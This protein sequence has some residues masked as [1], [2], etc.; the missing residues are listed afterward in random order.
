M[1]SSGIASRPLLEF[2]GFRMGFKDE[3]SVFN[4]LDDLSFSIREGTVLGLV[5]ESGCGKSMTS[6]AIMRLLP[7]EAVVQGGDIRFD[8]A[9]LLG[10]SARE[11]EEIR[12]RN[13]GMIF[14]EPMTSLNP[15]YTVGRQIGEVFRIHRSDMRSDQVRTETLEL[16]RKVGISNA[17]Q[18]F[19]QYPHQLSGGMRQR[20]M[21]AIAIA[22]KPQLLIADEP[23]TALDVTIQAQVLELMQVLKEQSHG[24]IML[25][26]HNLG[27]V[28]ETCQEAVIM[29]AGQIVERGTI[30]RL[31]DAP[32]HPYTRGLLASVPSKSDD[33]LHS[34]PGT[35]PTIENFGA[36]CRFAPR[37]EHRQ[38]RCDQESPRMVAVESGHD[39]ACWLFAADAR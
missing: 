39:V 8:G 3:S 2:Q 20:V 30:D 26:T 28:A 19:D 5:G 34:I 37:C 14:Q 12:G 22:C 10:R 23:T 36:G 29:Y 24:S 16:L 6:L 25:I 35:V 18:R 11:M 1:V 33:E 17:E 32:A 21:I 13:I 9:S 4:L 38:A 15:V 31:F 7:P 27:V